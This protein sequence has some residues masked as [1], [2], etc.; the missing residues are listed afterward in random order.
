MKK[1]IAIAPGIFSDF[2]PTD[3]QGRWKDSDRVRFR[4]GMP[5][6]IGG[7][8]NAI[9]SGGA[10]V[11]FRGICRRLEDWT[12]LAGQSWI[13]L[14]T[15]KRLYIYSNGVLYNITPQRATSN[16]TD[17]IFTDSTGSYDPTGGSDA[18]Y[19]RVEDS[20]HG[21]AVGDVVTISGSG[22]VG[23]ITPDGDYEVRAVV[24]GD[25][26]TLKHSSA[27]TSTVAG[28]GG[29]V[30]VVYELAAG[31]AVAGVG[32]GYGLGAYNVGT[33]GTPR[34]GTSQ[35]VQPRTW[36]LE[37]W[38]EDLLASP[39]NGTVYWW[40]RSVGTGTPAAEVTQAPDQITRMLLSSED[41]HLIALGCTDLAAAFDPLLVRWCDQEDFTVWTPAVGNTAGTRRLDG[42]AFIVTGL[43]TRYGTLI[44]TDTTLHFMQFIGPPNTF[45]IRKVA[46]HTSIAG[47][48]A[49][50]DAQGRA[51]WMGKQ[52]FYIYD[53]AV[54][55]L[56]CPVWNKIFKDISDIQG[57]QVYASINELFNEIRWEFVSSVAEHNSKYVVY[58]YAEDIWYTG[59]MKRSAMHDKSEIFGK[60]F[61]T[62]TEGIG[63]S[64]DNVSQLF[65]HETGSDDDGAQ[66]NEYLESFDIQF[67][68]AEGFIHVRAIYPDFK[69]L[70]GNINFTLRSKRRPQQSSYTEKAYPGVGSMDERVGVRIRGQQ[71]AF[72]VS[73]SGIGDSWR[74]G[75]HEFEFEADGER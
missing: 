14:G 61:G 67:P 55:V 34:S 47:P 66:M 52:N 4:N 5:E 40:D 35:V 62:D 58:N 30:D 42:G 51:Y 60:P 25:V 39:L 72:R 21:A 8:D 36:S 37:N 70:I 27:A 73:D 65:V 54:N 49:A 20:T 22:A 16:L 19:F 7:W 9:L 53:G 45:S 74:M 29:S 63:N 71:I 13:G 1:T 6:K 17:P 32:D 43:V 31:N 38:G 68:D 33:F 64:D 28:G 26:Y 44:W 50:I 23:G 3:V 59:T 46:D 15:D 56:P 69:E 2:T 18:S 48:N 12:D 11:T 75:S 57:Y 41:R 24:S 10:D